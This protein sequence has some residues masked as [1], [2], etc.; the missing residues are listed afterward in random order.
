[1]VIDATT[2]GTGSY[3]WSAAAE[4]SHFENVLFVR[5][6]PVVQSYAADFESIWK[7]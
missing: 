2:L 6:S 4:E 1:M 7:R 5:G 3:V